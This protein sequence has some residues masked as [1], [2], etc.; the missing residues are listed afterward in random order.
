MK[1]RKIFNFAVI[2]IL[3]LSFTMS[4]VA[5]E[6]SAPNYTVA[7]MVIEDFSVYR[8]GDSEENRTIDFKLYTPDG[9][10]IEDSKYLDKVTLTTE[11]Q[12]SISNGVIQSSADYLPGVYPVKAT[13]YYNGEEIATTSFDVNVRKQML[14]VEIMKPN[15]TLIGYHEV[16]WGEKISQPADVLESKTEFGGWYSDREF[17]KPFDFNAPIE[18]DTNVYAKVVPLQSVE[19]TFEIK[20]SATMEEGEYV[21]VSG[22]LDNADPDSEWGAVLLEDKGDGIWSKTISIPADIEELAWNVY[23]VKSTESVVHSV[24]GSSAN[25]SN[26]ILESTNKIELE[27]T[28]WF[29]RAV[30]VE[31]NRIKNGSF[32]DTIATGGYSVADTGWTVEGFTTPASEILLRGGAEDLAKSGY[33]F[34]D[35]G[36]GVKYVTDANTN[37]SL[38]QF[39][40]KGSNLNVGDTVNFSVF[41]RRGN[42]TGFKILIGNNEFT[43][44]D[45]AQWAWTEVTYQY[46]LQE[47]DFGEDG[48]LK[49]GLSWTISNPDSWTR[50]DDFSLTVEGE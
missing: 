28:Q 16:E 1:S 15:G 45:P 35:T 19:V 17:T 13:A 30:I 23:A 31:G 22:N 41:I 9:K 24:R 38:Y 42:S 40:P 29:G 3:I 33:A 12:L 49:V 14:D 39:I 26:M 7:A 27:V 4:L 8:L 50:V 44:S 48:S 2:A 43:V 25:L 11:S 47:S 37:V 32:E 6:P 18:H 36:D 34:N 46:T 21:W 10:R 5:C 20:V